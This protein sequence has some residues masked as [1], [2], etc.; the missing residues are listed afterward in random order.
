M[1]AVLWAMLAALWAVPAVLWLRAVLAMHTV[2]YAMV[3]SYMLDARIL[4]PRIHNSVS[5]AVLCCLRSWLECWVT[6]VVRLKC[7]LSMF[8][9]LMKGNLTSQARCSIG[10]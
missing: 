1:L 3:V 9:H 2:H 10:M 5:V 7:G 8:A 4:G 6:A